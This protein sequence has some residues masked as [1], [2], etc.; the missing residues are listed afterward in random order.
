MLLAVMQHTF[1][2]C[3][4]CVAAAATA[5]VLLGGA[6]P[7]VLLLCSSSCWYL[8]REWMTELSSSDIPTAVQSQFH[9]PQFPV[10]GAHTFADDYVAGDGAGGASGWMARILKQK[11][12]GSGG[13]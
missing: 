9:L 2:C 6:G 12:G 13:Q 8:Q 7:A 4:C 3:F 10:V 5:Y 1:L 11:P